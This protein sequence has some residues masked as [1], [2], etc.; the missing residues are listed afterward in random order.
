LLRSVRLLGEAP[1]LRRLLAPSVGDHAQER[2]VQHDIGHGIEPARAQIFGARDE[3]AG[4]VVDQVG[5]RAGPEDFLDHGV[6]RGRIANVDAVALDRAAVFAAEIGGG[7]IAYRLA[8]SADEYVGAE[9]QEFLDHSFA[10]PG[11]AAGHQNAPAVKKSVLEHFLPLR[12]SG[13]LY[14]DGQG[15]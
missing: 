9:R 5:E 12:V 8:A 1:G 13:P 11:A 3:V 7:D 15:P 6:D 2:S 14:H 10:E 4:G